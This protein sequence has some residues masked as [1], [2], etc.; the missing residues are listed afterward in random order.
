MSP[1]GWAAGKG[2]GGE[3]AAVIGKNLLSLI[4]STFLYG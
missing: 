2:V 3:G 4:V 1:L